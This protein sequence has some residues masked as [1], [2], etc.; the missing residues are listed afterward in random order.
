L[1]SRGAVFDP[2]EGGGI[3]PEAGDVDAEGRLVG[4]GE[5]GEV[6]LWV[7]VPI[8]VWSEGAGFLEGSCALQEASVPSRRGRG[9]SWLA[10]AL[11]NSARTRDRYRSEDSPHISRRESTQSLEIR[12]GWSG[13]LVKLGVSKALIWKARKPERALWKAS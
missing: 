6:V 5:V 9:K 2:G 8:I 10:P 12:V 13:S 1:P 11:G 7:G 3:G 4:R